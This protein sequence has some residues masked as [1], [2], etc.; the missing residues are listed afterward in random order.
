MHLLA[1]TPGSVAET[2]EPVD[3]GQTPADV[4]V[5]SAAD[6]ELAMLAEARAEMT[7]PPTLRLAN[8]AHL[9]H[10]MSVDLHLDACATRSRLVIVRLLG[11][12]GY[13]RY[14][15]EQFAARLRDAGV[16]LALLPGDDKPD[17]ELRALSTVPDPDYDALWS[18]LTE[19]GLGNAVGFLA[20]ARA[21]LDGSDRP[22]AA[23]PL[24]KSAPFWPGTGPCDL[25]T[26]RQHWTD[27]AAVVVTV[28]RPPV[29][30][31]EVPDALVPAVVEEA[32]ASVFFALGGDG[33]QA[34]GGASD[35]LD[36]LFAQAP[37][38]E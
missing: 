11:G 16:P 23:R 5:I 8:L 38:S 35:V 21:M 9:S 30:A 1:A 12:L 34:W 31:G 17:A 6:T 3:L 25:D 13:W 10:P 15:A 26:I 19:G 37:D 33:P 4:V 7:A 2:E 27:G 20:H 36:D 18:F 22:P 24:L 28:V 32:A 14:G 29:D